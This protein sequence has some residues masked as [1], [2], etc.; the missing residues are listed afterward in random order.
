MNITISEVTMLRLITILFLAALSTACAVNPVTGE[1]QLMF[2]PEG[3]DAEIGQSQYKP[4]QQSQGGLYY[5]DP[6]LTLYVAGVGKK[7]AAVSDRPDLPYE[8]VILNNSVPNAWALPSGKI[9]LNR[10]LLIRLEDEAQLAAVLSH[11]I[12]HAA[13]RHSAQRM[14]QGMIVQYGMMGLGMAAEGTDYKD[15]IIG[16]AA[17]GAQLTMAQYSQ[18]HELESDQ[19]GM[20]YMAKAG[21]DLN[22]AVELQQLFV[23]LSNNQ[24]SNFLQGLFASHPPSPDRVKANREHVTAFASAGNYRGKTEFQKHMKYLLSK[25]NAYNAQDK[26][27]ALIAKKE[28]TA[29]MT[30]IEKAI[31]AEP[32]EALFYATKGDIYSAQGKDALAVKQYEKSVSLFPEQFS[33]YLKKGISNE[34]LGNLEQAKKDFTRSAQLLPTSV[35]ELGLGNIAQL[36]GDQRNAIL[37]YGKASQAEGRNG[38]NARIKLAKL[39]LPNQPDKYIKIKHMLGKNRE[40]QAYAE[41]HSEITVIEIEVESTVTDATGKLVNK[42]RWRIKQAIKPRSR[43][44]IEKD[45]TIATLP[46]GYRVYSKILSADIVK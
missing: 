30:E 15:L 14:Q 19:Y 9:A 2:L 7:L 31:K 21:Y 28:F 38:Q 44:Q 10:G 34:K 42:E 37:H 26:A 12:V 32:N 24:Q 41:N 18:D 1:Q 33:S 39:E 6:E 29:A 36:Q 25:T 13:A 4:A 5:L 23:E 40:L 22:A 16:G 35:A 20:K 11:E 46:E 17:M 3:Q 45:P 8:F 43:S 27:T